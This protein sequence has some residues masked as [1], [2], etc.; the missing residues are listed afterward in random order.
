MSFMGG[1]VIEEAGTSLHSIQ[2]A[3][4][5]PFLQL[6]LPVILRKAHSYVEYS[7]FLSF[8]PHHSYT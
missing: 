5:Y 7:Y 8:D 3:D 6:W 1:N 2:T 4:T